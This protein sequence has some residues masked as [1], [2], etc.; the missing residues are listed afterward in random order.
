MK[1]T[2]MRNKSNKQKIIIIFGLIIAS[3]LLIAVG[4]S[5]YYINKINRVKLDENK[6]GVTDVNQVPINDDK[7]TQSGRNKVKN[8]LLLG[9]D[10]Q[11]KASDSNII[12]SLDDTSK[13]I[14]LSSLMRDTYV[15]YGPDKV[16]KLNYAYHYGGPELS[17][18]TINEKFKLDITD[19][20]KVDFNGLTKIIDQVGGVEINVRSSEVKSLNGYAKDIASIGKTQYTPISRS[21]NQV[22]NGQ[23][24]T[25]YCRIRYVG[26]QDY[27]RTERQRRVL[28]QIFSKLKDK[29]VTEYPTILSNILPYIETSLNRIEIISVATTISNY[30]KNG[31]KETRCPY[32][33]LR[34]DAMVNG[35]YYM[36]WNEEENVKKLHQFIYLQ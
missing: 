2:K 9:V 18:K 15:E 13:Q 30:G 11:E 10:N 24:A 31:I 1:E 36:K 28:E 12:I 33:G 27:E 20:V 4:G 7:S 14:K 35:I 6:I 8:I 17:V 3:A 26:N 32:D 19:Y 25:A 22:L 21:G 16:N 23:Q 29:S 34:Q 5:Y